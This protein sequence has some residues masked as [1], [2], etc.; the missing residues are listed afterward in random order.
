MNQQTSDAVEILNLEFG[1]APEYQEMLAEERIFSQAEKAVYDARKSMGLS[2]KDIAGDNPSARVSA[3]LRQWQ[4]EYGLP[5][6]PDGKSHTS[7]QELFTQWDAEDAALTPEEAE[8]ER[9]LW[10]D[11]PECSQGITI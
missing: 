10:D 9:H 1:D 8:A 3:L 6:R 11:N 2:Q 7:V 4:Q 5:A